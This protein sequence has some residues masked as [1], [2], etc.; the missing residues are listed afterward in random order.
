MFRQSHG[1]LNDLHASKRQPQC[2]NSPHIQSKWRLRSCTCELLGGAA[3]RTS[4]ADFKAPFLSNIY[5]ARAVRA[6]VTRCFRVWLLPVARLFARYPLAGEPGAFC[7]RLWR[8]SEARLTDELR[9][10]CCVIQN[11][12]WLKVRLVRHEG[13]GVSWSHMFWEETSRFHAAAYFMMQPRSW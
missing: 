11:E 13:H 6:V 10:C 8:G 12:G 2:R 4:R 9:F 5:T 7:G 3:S 1:H